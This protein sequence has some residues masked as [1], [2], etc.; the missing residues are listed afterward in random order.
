MTPAA[1]GWAPA[2]LARRVQ[3]D[4]PRPDPRVAEPGSRFHALGH[5][6][7]ALIGIPNGFTVADA[8]VEYLALR[9]AACPT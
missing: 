5:L 4:R 8:A 2:L 3:A 9:P 6:A 1:P 7:H